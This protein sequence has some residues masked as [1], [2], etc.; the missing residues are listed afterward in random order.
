[1]RPVR[2]HRCQRS[3]LRRTRVAAVPGLRGDHVQDRVRVGVPAVR[4]RLIASRNAF[5]RV[6]P[7]TRAAYIRAASARWGTTAAPIQR[8]GAAL[9]SEGLSREPSTVNQPSTGDAGGSGE[10]RIPRVL[11]RSGTV[12][13]Y[14]GGHTFACLKINEEDQWR[15]D[16]ARGCIQRRRP[17]A[18]GAA[19][20]VGQG[21]RPPANV[22]LYQDAEGRDSLRRFRSRSLSRHQLR[23][24]GRSSRGGGGQRS[25]LLQRV[26]WCGPADT[27]IVSARS[28]VS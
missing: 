25:V 9:P 6:A 1:M 4:N 3:R 22:S 24:R 8:T 13:P 19:P 16:A 14:F 7:E 12:C 26:I 15:A 23:D 2:V 27:V 28:S 11:S 5:R 21:A 10:S 17:S 20:R 18:V